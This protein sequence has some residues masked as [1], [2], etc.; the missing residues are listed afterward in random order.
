MENAFQ[1]WLQSVLDHMKD[2]N[3][4]TDEE[5]AEIFK[6]P[7]PMFYEAYEERLGDV[8]TANMYLELHS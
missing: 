3:V 2:Y 4:I 6:A 7:D 1:Y 8:D 5:A